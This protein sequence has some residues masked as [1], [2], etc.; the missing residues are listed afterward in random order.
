MLR[1]R[2]FLMLNVQVAQNTTSA[3]PGS[4]TPRRRSP[5]AGSRRPS[6]CWA[7]MATWMLPGPRGHVQGMFNLLVSR[8]H[9]FFAFFCQFHGQSLVNQKRKATIPSFP[10]EFQ[11]CLLFLLWSTA[12]PGAVPCTWWM[13][14]ACISTFSPRIWSSVTTTTRWVGERDR[15]AAYC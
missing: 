6:R 14:T 3:S 7:G 10:A 8:C 2:D 4:R 13:R 5:T 9:K 1:C 15:G 11:S 12:G